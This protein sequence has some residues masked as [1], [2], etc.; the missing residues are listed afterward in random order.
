[1]EV[2]K[3][4]KAWRRG[5]CFQK[6][7][8]IQMAPGFGLDNWE[9]LGENG[10]AG[11]AGTEAWLYWVEKGTQQLQALDRACYTQAKGL[12]GCTCTDTAMQ[13]GHLGA[14]VILYNFA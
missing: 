8:I 4:Q 10:F 5:M 7:N 11:V 2:E 6:E 9:L 12:M 14:G 13:L 3:G 1:M